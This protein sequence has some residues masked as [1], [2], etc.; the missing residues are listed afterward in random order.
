MTKQ[1]NLERRRRRR[2]QVAQERADRQAERESAYARRGDRHVVELHGRGGLHVKFDF[3]GGV[4]VDIDPDS[5]NPTAGIEEKVAMM[6]KLID[7]AESSKP[8]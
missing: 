1:E 6:Q 7:E 2:E 8:N 3:G 4:V 5:P